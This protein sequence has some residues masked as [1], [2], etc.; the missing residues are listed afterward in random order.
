[1]SGASGDDMVGRLI[2]QA[3]EEDVGEGDWTTLWTVPAETPG[4]AVIIAKEALV[5][6][7]SEI[8]R[9]VFITVDAGMMVEVLTP[10][11]SRVEPG[12][13]VLRL[14][15]AARAI[16][17]AERVALN[18]LGRL[19][20]IA[21]LTR[22]FVDA[23]EGTGTTILDTRKTTPGW[24]MLEKQAVGVGGG[25][26]HRFGLHDMVL[27][28]DNHI[29]AAGGITSAL[30]GVRRANRQGL[31]VEVEV[32]SLEQLEEALSG[33]PD[34]VLLDNMSIELL[35]ACVRLVRSRAEGTRPELEASG[36][37]SLER[38]RAVAATGVDFISVGALT[39]SAASVDFSLRF[40]GG[41]FG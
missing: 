4:E 30:A 19:S 33:R 29:A 32:T 27:V 17:T 28:K 15:G 40:E 2:A 26:N 36:N 16:L 25:G 31:P 14:R 37:M 1:M 9:E 18:F 39:H 13:P 7:G 38:V 8:A 41:V 34:R 3:L 12:S 22:R 6:A 11:G 10:D 21:T 23:V 35:E 20:G 24:R 5:V